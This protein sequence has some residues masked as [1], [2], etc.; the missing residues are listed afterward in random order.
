MSTNVKSIPSNRDA[1]GLNPI[2]AAIIAAMSSEPARIWTFGELAE[3]L[4]ESKRAVRDAAMPMRGRAMRLLPL[5]RP[6]AR[7]ALLPNEI[8]LPDNSPL[9]PK[10]AP[11]QPAKPQEARRG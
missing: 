10:I 4:G 5:E 6:D 9:R 3:K 11:T 7:Y 8:W 1:R 2:Q